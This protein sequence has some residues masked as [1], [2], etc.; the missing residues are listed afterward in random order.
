MV[1]DVNDNKPTVPTSELAVCEKEGE[2][3][4]VLVVAEDKDQNHFS[5]PFSFSLPAN[6]DGTWSVTRFNGTWL[7]FYPFDLRLLKSVI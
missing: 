2:F 1:E 6:N 3:G 7:Y 4:S 5:S